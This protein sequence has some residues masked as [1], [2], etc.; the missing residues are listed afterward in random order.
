MRLRVAAAVVL[1]GDIVLVR[2][3]KAGVTY[4]LLPGGGVEAGETLEAALVREVREETGL[5]V[6]VDRPLFISETLD[7]RGGRHLLNVTFLATA[8]GGALTKRPADP[9]VEAVD[10]VAPDALT[11]LDLRPPMAAQLARAVRDG[12]ADETR[13]L[14]TLWVDEGGPAAGAAEGRM[15]GRR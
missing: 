12:F 13:Y 14:G 15:S 9:R 10:L 5:E 6:T 7:P 2:H 4:H 1:D 3:R 8:V 11:G